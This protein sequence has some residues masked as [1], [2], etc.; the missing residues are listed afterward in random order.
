M[1]F[2]DFHDFRDSLNELYD[3]RNR[4]IH[5]YIIS[6]LQTRDILPVV[7][8]LL[9]IHE[10]VRLVRV[11]ERRAADSLRVDALSLPTAGHGRGF[12]L[13]DPSARVV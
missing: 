11:D 3:F 2:C 5:R 9:K 6:S 7:G 8:K 1:Q 12:V 4:I 10:E 13:E